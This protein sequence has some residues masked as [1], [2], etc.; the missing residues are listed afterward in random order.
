MPEVPIKVYEGDKYAKVIDL[1]KSHFDNHIDIG[2]SVSVIHK[3]KIIFEVSGGYKDF[4]SKEPYT[5]DTLQAIFSSSKVVTSIV[6]AWLVDQGYLDYD[7]PIS[8]YWPEFSQGCKDKVLLKDVMRHDAGLA[9]VDPPLEY[10]EIIDPEKLYNRL[11]EQV[12]VFDGEDKRS[13]HAFT[14][15]FILNGIAQRV[16]PKKRTIGAILKEEITDKLGVEFYYGIRDKEVL[17]KNSVWYQYPKTTWKPNND[18]IDVDPAVAQANFLSIFPLLGKAVNLPLYKNTK[19]SPANH[20]EFHIIEIPAGNGHSTATSLA[21]IV[22]QAIS[23]NSIIS[24]KTRKSLFEEASTK[25]DHALKSEKTLTKA[26]FNVFEYPDANLTVVGG[27]GAGGSYIVIHPEL[28]FVFAYVT[29]ANQLTPPG[30]GRG[31]DLL[32][33][34]YE[35]FKQNNS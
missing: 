33:V 5:K 19:L 12:H 22:S 29:N 26:G 14:Q 1:F 32:K 10:D 30:F 6:I 15:G 3:D 21:K 8:K 24:E 17:K 35:E 31:L 9:W 18:E 7:A 2:A 23:K 11:A 4:E 28:E 13:Y 16:D 25:R 27:S 20:P 34:F